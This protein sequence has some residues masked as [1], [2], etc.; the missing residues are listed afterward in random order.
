MKRSTLLVILLCLA[1]VAFAQRTYQGKPVAAKAN[2]HLIKGYTQP[3]P[4]YAMHPQSTPPVQPPMAP[5]DA[6]DPVTFVAIGSSAN[7]FGYGYNNGAATFTWY[8]KA[9]NT[10]TNTHRMGGPVGPSGQ[11]SGDLAYDVSFDGGMNWTNQVKVYTSNISGGDYNLDA[12]RYPQGAV[13]NPMGNT[14][15]A[16][17]YLAYFAANLDGT[18]GGQWGGYSYGVGRFGDILDTTKHLLSSDTS[19]NYRQGIP[20]AFTICNPTNTAIMA[21]AS[22]LNSYQVYMGDIIFMRGIFNDGLGDFEYERF[23]S[24]AVCNYARYLKMAFDPSGQIGYVYWNNY[25]G[26]FPEYD[27]EEWTYPLLIKSTDG[28]ETWSDVFSIALTGPDCPDGIKNWMSDEFLEILFEGLPMPERDELLF[29]TP[30]FNSDIS[31]DAWGNPHLATSVHC[32]GP[33]LD[34]GYWFTLEGSIGIF[35]IYS[36]DDENTNWQAVN[37][38]AVR[39]M[40]HDFPVTG[41]DPLPEYNRVQIASDAEGKYMFLA[42]LDTRIEEVETNA[43]PDIFARGF[44]LVD[45]MITNWDDPEYPEYGLYGARYVTLYSE[46][47]WTSYF[48]SLSHYVIDEGDEGSKTFTLPMVIE[49][50]SDVNNWGAPVQFK[51]L[52]DFFFSEADFV[53]ATGNEAI[54]GVGLEE[55]VASAVTSVSQNYPNPFNRNSTVVVTTQEATDMNLVVTNLV[56]QKVL[57]IKRGVVGAGTH[58]FDIDGSRLTNGV[59]FYTVTAG[60]QKITHKMVVE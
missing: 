35:D 18:N 7:A 48:M 11:Y 29:T 27:A 33:G 17:A 30:Y 36:I 25:D 2:L 19:D 38:G 57:E 34:P 24:P 44:D 32:W 31:V 28:G 60:K 41:S 21:D 53:L 37:V 6:P 20:T 9:T 10:V 46:H 49:S 14:D 26:S 45:N 47:M 55:P 52:Q 16:N 4:V 3:G 50:P 23:L 1:V 39:T 51:Y 58:S 8:D 54:T 40:D 56:G 15:P 42:W 59:Y 5:A 13:Y 43:S 12:A 22:L